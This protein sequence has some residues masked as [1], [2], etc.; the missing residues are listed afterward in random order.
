ML[1]LRTVNLCPQQ[2]LILTRLEAYNN[3]KV[4]RR[5][6]SFRTQF[7]KRHPTWILDG[8]VS[9][10][11]PNSLKSQVSARAKSSSRVIL[12]ATEDQILSVRS[13]ARFLDAAVLCSAAV[14]SALIS[15]RRKNLGST[16]LSVCRIPCLEILGRQ[17]NH[18]LQGGLFPSGLV[19]NAV[20]VWLGLKRPI[21]LSPVAFLL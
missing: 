8:L 15:S 1:E 3:L 5:I 9:V 20:V 16:L 21:S 18:G 14:R 13:A 11:P 4:V 7:L 6:T 10:C 2:L 19:R 17:W 12:R